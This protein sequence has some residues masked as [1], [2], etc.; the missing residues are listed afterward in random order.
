MTKI[1]IE[2]DTYTNKKLLINLVGDIFKI[3]DI[4]YGIID[5]LKC[6]ILLVNGEYYITY[7]KVILNQLKNYD[8]KNI[9]VV[10]KEHRVNEFSN[11]KYHKLYP[12]PEVLL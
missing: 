2:Y 11:M 10:L 9:S 1:K 12:V 7:S 6:A 5:G 3:E 4:E 8:V